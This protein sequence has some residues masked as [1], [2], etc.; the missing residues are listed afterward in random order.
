MIIQ[1]ILN[2]PNSCSTTV[3]HHS[4]TLYL[5]KPGAMV[6]HNRQVTLNTFSIKCELEEF[7]EFER[8]CVDVGGGF[9]QEKG[10]TRMCNHSSIRELV[11]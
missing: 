9:R 2:K 10:G 11:K 7:A 6:E 1:D 8:V 4:A 5:D 3:R